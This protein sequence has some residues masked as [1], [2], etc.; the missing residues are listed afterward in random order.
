MK[1]KGLC[2]NGKLLAKL[3]MVEWDRMWKNIRKL[4][5]NLR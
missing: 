5:H 1:I 3:T 4:T 2:G